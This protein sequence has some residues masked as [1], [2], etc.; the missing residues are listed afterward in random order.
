MVP[1]SSMELGPRKQPDCLPLQVRVR[2]QR[3]Y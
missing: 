3:G 2:E 1:M